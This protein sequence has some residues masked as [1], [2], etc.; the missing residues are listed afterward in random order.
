MNLA[1]RITQLRKS[2]GISQE[3]LADKIGV[4][5]QAVSKWESEQSVP[6]TEKIVALSDIFETTTDFLLKGIEPVKDIKNKHNAVLF[7]VGATALNAAGLLLSIAVWF[8]YQTIFAAVIGLIIMLLGTGIFLIGQVIDTKDKPIA[9][10]FFILPNVW[11]LL[12]MPMSFCFNILCALHGRYY[13]LFSPIP[14]IQNSNYKAFILFWIVYI[15][16]CVGTDIFTA[17]YFAKKR[18]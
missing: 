12:F 14:L 2:K 6:D 5:R 7:A 15:A 4:S 8:E 3:E 18:N 1:D 10:I 9:K 17:V 16:V 11:I 13:P